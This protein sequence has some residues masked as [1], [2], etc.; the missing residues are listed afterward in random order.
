M[1]QILEEAV[2]S[3]I[4]Q[5]NLNLIPAILYTSDKSQYINQI[6]ILVSTNQT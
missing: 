6:N 3:R 2:E 5:F 4:T 1:N